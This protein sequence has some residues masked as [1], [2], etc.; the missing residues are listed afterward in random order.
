MPDRLE[1]S[2]VVDVA[3]A[4][5]I[6]HMSQPD[7]KEK[8]W[9]PDD[10]KDIKHQN[11]RMYDLVTYEKLV[12]TFSNEI[13]KNSK[14][15]DNAERIVIPREYKYATRMKTGRVYV[16]GFGVQS[17]SRKLR[18]IFTGKYLV[19]Y[20]IKNC[21]PTILSNMVKGYNKQFPDDTLAQPNLKSYINHREDHLKNF[22]KHEFLVCL[23]S[24]RLV[25]N[26]KDHFKS[27]PDGFWTD[28]KFL[29]DFHREKSVIFDA[30]LH[31]K[32][33]FDHYK[34]RNSGLTTTNDK[35]PISSIVSKMLCIEENDIIQSV[36]L[37]EHKEVVP[38]FDGYMVPIEEKDKYDFLLA[39]PKSHP[40]SWDIKNNNTDD[41]D[42]I[43]YSYDKDKISPYEEQKVEF[44][45]KVSKITAGKTEYLVQS[46]N[47]NNKPIFCTLTEKQMEQK[48]RD[49]GTEGAS[50]FITQWLDDPHKKTYDGIVFN[51]YGEGKTDPTP[52]RYFNTFHPFPYKIKPDL[53]DAVNFK[54]EDL[55]GEAGDWNED[56]KTIKP[57][58]HYMH[59]GIADSNKEYFDYMMKWLAHIVQKPDELTKVSPS[60]Q[61]STG[62]GKGILAANIIPALLGEEY[63]VSTS[64]IQEILPEGNNCFNASMKGKLFINFNETGGIDVKKSIEQLKHQIDSPF[65]R[66]RELYKEVFTEI[67]RINIMT[68]S[69]QNSA[70]ECQIDCRRIFAIICGC[71]MKGNQ[72]FW[73]KYTDWLRS[74]GYELI[75]NYLM[76]INLDK[77]CAEKDRPKTEVF[78]ELQE[79][80]TP[81]QALWLQDLRDDQY[82]TWTHIIYEEKSCLF[83]SRMA[84]IKQY[85][86]YATDM[87]MLPDNWKKKSML[88][89][90]CLKGIVCKKGF[91]KEINGVLV[92][93]DLFCRKSIS[94]YLSEH[95]L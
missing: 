50:A 89:D 4:S 84:W 35:N 60:I 73:K 15:H 95:N 64:K 8:F 23:H 53:A 67:N 24:D 77:F 52:E 93:G 7:F 10:K 9:Q 69:N 65:N 58:L 41:P 5:Y 2:D 38:M 32:Q 86:Q 14:A 43:E 42:F 31:N 51:P 26:K 70:S 94:K 79:A 16:K 59:Y 27:K 13:L 87:A 49:Y 68:T 34:K 85:K 40:I 45:K 39:L 44:E 17:L 47:I 25:S 22:S 28:S 3:A 56:W 33:F 36:I 21:F 88:L 66:I 19:D 62:V 91:Q 1:F 30:F 29:K 57:F 74:D 20:D 63:C 82:D 55:V 80:N 6:S 78:L 46:I 71:Y 83:V 37:P 18:K 76:R 81:P 90:M 12:R 72:D 48:Y 75:Y 92:R 54:V 11:D 61:G